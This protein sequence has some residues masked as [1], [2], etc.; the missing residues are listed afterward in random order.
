MWA[1]LCFKYDVC[2]F[3]NFDHPI[4]YCC[5]MPDSINNHK[6]YALSEITESITRMFEKHYSQPY[7]IKAELSA[8]NYYPSSGHCFP[9][10][11]EK[12]NG[13]VKAQLKATIWKDDLHYISAKFEKETKEQFREGLNLMFLAHVKFS[14]VYGLSLQIID[15]EPLFTLGA[16]ALDKLKTINTLKEEG[17]FNYNRSLKIPVLIKNLAIISVESSKGYNDLMVTLNGNRYGYKVLTK[18]FPAVLQGKGAVET[19][20]SQLRTIRSLQG[21]YDAVAIVRGGGDDV[22]LSCYDHLTLAR[23]MATFNI[24]VI[25]GIGHSTNETVTEMVACINKITP[26]DVAH[27][28]LNLFMQQDNLLQGMRQSLMDLTSSFFA[29]EFNKYTTTSGRFVNNARYLIF[30][31]RIAL[32]RHENSILNKPAALLK[33]EENTQQNYL[34]KLLFIEKHF[35]NVHSTA[36][37]AKAEKIRILDPVNVLKRGYSIVRVNGKVPATAA[38]VHCGDTIHITGYS[39]GIAARVEEVSNIDVNLSE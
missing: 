21:I 4:Q 38:D 34:K 32:G 31:N 15:I 39:L 30:N 19:I 28:I 7:W 20:T 33:K 17:V 12:I 10:M 14:S 1:L 29:N 37:S 18:L 6:V 16:M 36:L 5:L 13:Q 26:T 27:Y 24:P 23:E 8:L 2:F 11:V 35:L 3:H 22:G 9:V 25:T